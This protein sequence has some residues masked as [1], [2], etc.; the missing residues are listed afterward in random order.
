M[1][2]VLARDRGRRDT[3]ASGSNTGNRS[4]TEAKVLATLACPVDSSYDATSSETCSLTIRELIPS[5][6]VPA[7]L[8]CRELSDLEARGVLDESRDQKDPYLEG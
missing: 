3:A 4:F 1:A 5:H 8:N 2:T 6:R 7:G